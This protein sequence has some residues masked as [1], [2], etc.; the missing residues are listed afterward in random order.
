MRLQR[1]LGQRQ[2]LQPRADRP[3]LGG[4]GAMM[5][6]D[7]G[8][9][10]VDAGVLR[11]DD[12]EDRQPGLDVQVPG[13]LI[14]AVAVGLVDDDDVGNFQQA[15]LGGLD[16]VTGPGFRM[17]TVGSATAAISIS[18]CPTPTV[19]ARRCRNRVRRAAV[20]PRAQRQPARRG[21]R[22]WPPSGS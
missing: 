19:R 20:S 16:R 6:V 13:G 5:G 9:Q 12:L 22:G 10:L 7:G 14:G 2:D 11:R 21:A 4:I 15:R 3:A 1:T 18:D 8:G 17:A